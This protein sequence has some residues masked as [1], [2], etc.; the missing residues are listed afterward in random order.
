[1][2]VR[3]ANLIRPAVVVAALGFAAAPPAAAQWSAPTPRSVTATAKT[4]GRTER[5]AA[6]TEP[7]A[8]PPG[9]PVAGVVWIS[10]AVVVLI[11]FAWLAMRVGDPPKPADGV[12]N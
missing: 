11:F 1:M 5:P 8:E 6:P 7:A 2:F 12:P 10:G 3:T 9:D 4:A